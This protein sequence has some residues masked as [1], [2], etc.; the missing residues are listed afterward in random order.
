MLI[1]DV[2]VL[3]LVHVVANGRS[4]EKFDEVFKIDEEAPIFFILAI[5]LRARFYGPKGAFI[6]PIAV[7]LFHSIR[8]PNLDQTVLFAIS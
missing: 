2:I 3:T 8:V 4:S 7:P 6:A 1:Y 5:D